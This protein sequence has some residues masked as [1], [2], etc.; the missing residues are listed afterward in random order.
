MD[1]ILKRPPV[2]IAFA[3]IFAGIVYSYPRYWAPSFAEYDHVEKLTSERDAYDFAECVSEQNQ[4]N[5]KTSMQY[6]S[7]SIK[8]VPSGDIAL[9]SRD[10]GT[11]IN[12]NSGPLDGDGV[13]II[14]RV[15]SDVDRS[16]VEGIRNCA[17]E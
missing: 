17:E 10:K 12:I 9:R 11:F 2:L 5:P 3:I 16:V 6:L 4:D 15:K 8:A 14:V 1:S 13:S 7:R